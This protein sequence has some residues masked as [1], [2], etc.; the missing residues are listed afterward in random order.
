L[1]ALQ[2]HFKL[3]DE[4]LLATSSTG[5]IIAAIDPQNKEKITEALSQNGLSASFMGE[6]SENKDRVLLRN[7]KQES[8][9]LTSGDPYDRILSGK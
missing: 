3:T 6:F 7:G 2:S 4:Q 8:F 1:L 9:P 5:T